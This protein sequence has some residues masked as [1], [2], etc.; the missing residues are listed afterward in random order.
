MPP[1][2]PVADPL[3]PPASA[4][5]PFFVCQITATHNTDATFATDTYGFSE[6]WRTGGVWG[7][8]TGGRYGAAENPG[9][10]APGFTFA[11][12][13]YALCRS[14]EGEGGLFW[15]LVERIG[16]TTW[17]P[18][19]LV[20][21]TAPVSVSGPAPA[22]MDGIPLLVGDRILLKDQAATVE[23]GVYVVGATGISRA[24]DDDPRAGAV[25]AV[26][27]GLTH[28]GSLWL[29]LVVN[30]AIRDTTAGLWTQVAT[31]SGTDK[32]VVRW[33][34]PGGI[35]DSAAVVDDDGSLYVYNL[36]PA[37]T[38]TPFVRAY[39]L[40][41]GGGLNLPRVVLAPLGT[42]ADPTSKFTLV[43]DSAAGVMTVAGLNVRWPDV[44][45]NSKT[46]TFYSQVVDFTSFGALY[47]TFPAL[48]ATGPASE[49]FACTICAT[50][51]FVGGNG[52]VPT[53]SGT[54]YDTGSILL[55][56]SPD[57]TY[58]DFAF[59]H[60]DVSAKKIRL[61]V[62]EGAS[63]RV[64][65]YS[66]ANPNLTICGGLVTSIGTVGDVSTTVANVFTAPQ[67]VTS[68]TAPALSLQQTSSNASN[69]LIVKNIAGA[70]TFA[71]TGA[72][73]VTATSF[74][75][76]GA[77]LTNLSASAL[78]SGTVPDARLSA[79]VASAVNLGLFLTCY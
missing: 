16:P 70:I 41:A 54:M 2:N 9:V 78:A 17:K 65:V 25:V 27:D 62:Y 59:G 33:G 39:V 52:S 64:G 21:S 4:L 26:L 31:G 47:G 74:T 69:T 72:G 19:A 34:G 71:V 79:K 36:N 44:G 8:K 53:A 77:G 61:T 42:P 14:A 75:G 3:T 28:G 23:N 11:V 10:A 73:D 58:K 40:D 67:T 76:S 30:P 49:A 63:A 15:E 46:Y 43:A 57:P 20:A 13:D 37:V 18:P 50:R 5:S 68:P 22:T 66:S 7:L 32:H 48:V 24:A 29:R 6:V 1:R 45:G 56:A 55:G 35:T 38:A 60:P 12:G 51:F